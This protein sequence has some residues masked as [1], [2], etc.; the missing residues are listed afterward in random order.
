MTI[1]NPYWHQNFKQEWE[2]KY[3]QRNAIVRL[4]SSFTTK[5][6]K[7]DYKNSE[8]Q[9]NTATHTH[10]HTFHAKI[11]FLLLFS[12]LFSISFLLLALLFTFSWNSDPLHIAFALNEENR[13]K[14]R[15]LCAMIFLKTENNTL[16]SDWHT[17]L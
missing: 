12:F 4:E 3:M 11:L 9:I 16:N 14:I 6:T 17:F 1:T 8:I 5:T 7:K 15:V 13:C 10:T 2:W